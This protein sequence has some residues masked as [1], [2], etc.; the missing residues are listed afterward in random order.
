MILSRKRVAY[1]RFNH[2]HAHTHTLSLSLSHT[3]TRS[4]SRS[5]TDPADA[6]VERDAWTNAI[7]QAT[8][9]GVGSVGGKAST[10]GLLE[11]QIR[12]LTEVLRKIVKETVALSGVSVK[13]LVKSTNV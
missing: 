1:N 4:L 10:P 6:Q 9:A 13:E 2:S 11:S 8:S 12:K 5:S 7:V 3:H